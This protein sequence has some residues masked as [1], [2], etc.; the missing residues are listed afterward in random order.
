VQVAVA[1]PKHDPRRRTVQFPHAKHDTLACAG[2]H[3]TPVSLEPADSALTCTGCHAS[4][5]AESRDCSVCHRTSAITAPHRMPVQAHASC[6]ACH[7]RATV[8][9]LV[10]TRSFCLACHDQQQDHYGPKEC[11]ACHFQRT[12]AELRPKLTRASGPS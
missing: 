12:P 3:V 6:D 2:C 11:S 4:H 8:A 7:T 10:P 5:H 9:R 1:V